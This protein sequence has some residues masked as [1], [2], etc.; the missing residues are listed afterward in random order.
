M[1]CKFSFLWSFSLF[2]QNIIFNLVF[3][4]FIKFNLFKQYVHYFMKFV[5]FTSSLME[6][7]SLEP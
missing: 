7:E 1:L 6:K 5:R 2:N 4:S 3:P